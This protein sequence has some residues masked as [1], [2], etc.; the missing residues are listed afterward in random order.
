MR[1]TGPRREG[2]EETTFGSW[3]YFFN[4][5]VGIRDGEWKLRVERYKSPL[6][7]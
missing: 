2:E 7:N 6:I 3:D 4:W 1:E 5:F